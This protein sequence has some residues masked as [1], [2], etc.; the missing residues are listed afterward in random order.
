MTQ[1]NDVIDPTQLQ[2]FPLL[3]HIL[4]GHTRLPEV[5]SFTFVSSFLSSILHFF[6]SSFLLSSFFYFF[7]FFLSS[8]LPFF[9]FWSIVVFKLFFFVSRSFLIIFLPSSPPTHS[10]CTLGYSHSCYIWITLHHP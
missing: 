10:S 1:R 2:G 3:L 9:L 8:F 7:T 6:F 5:G 4:K